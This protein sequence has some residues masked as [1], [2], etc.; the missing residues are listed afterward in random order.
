MNQETVSEINRI[1]WNQSVYQVWI[2]KHGLPKDYALVLKANPSKKVAHY[3]KYLGD[4]K[5]KKV[6]NLLGSNGNK[7][8]SLAL[9]GAHV[10]VVDISNENKKYAIELATSAEVNINYIVSDVLNIPET[11]KLKDFDFVILEVGVLH[12]FIELLPLFNLIKDSLKVGG[13]FILRDYH[14]ILSKLVNVEDN[15]M[16]ASGDY[17]QN[18]LIEVDVAY[19]NLLTESERLELKKNKIRRWTIGDIVTWI[20]KSGLNI[21]SLE[22]EEGIRWAFPSNSP[23]GVQ[24][25]IPGLY[26][27]IASK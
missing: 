9:L 26:T 18:D 8:V 24:N 16:I 13:K 17:F 27:L 5:N 15:N 21:N 12:Y 2:N 25:R 6:A 19:H 14:P 7:A 3:L 23:E 10:T 11:N 4:V 22:E 20:S 1:G